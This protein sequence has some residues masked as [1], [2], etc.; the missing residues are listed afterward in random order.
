MK[1]WSLYVCIVSIFV[2][3]T[4]HAQISSLFFGMGAI[5]STDMPK[6]SYGILSHPPL[7]WTAIEGTERGVYDFDSTDAFVTAAPKDD[8]GVAQI[9][10]VFGWTP[11]WAVASQSNCTTQNSGLVV[12]TVPPVII[13]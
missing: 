8:R 11:G 4:A 9:D 12:C 13:P 10:I 5:Q 7:A 6:V 1:T 3:A 2:V